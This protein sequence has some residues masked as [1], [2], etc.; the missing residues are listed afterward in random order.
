MLVSF[1]GALSPFMRTHERAEKTVSH[2]TR[3]LKRTLF[4]HISDH[5][6]CTNSNE[7]KEGLLGGIIALA[8]NEQPV[9]GIVFPA[10]EDGDHSPTESPCP[11]GSFTH[12]KSLPVR[13]SKHLCFCL[14]YGQTLAA[15]GS[16]DADG[17]GV[18]HRSHVAI[19]ML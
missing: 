19:L 14:R 11:P 6:S 9:S 7:K 8:A 3:C 5:L 16:L 4:E 17:F 12:G 2:Q 13:G 10:M 18:C 15:S 1:C